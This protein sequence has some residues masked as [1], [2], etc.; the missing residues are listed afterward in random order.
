MFDTRA[1]VFF[2][3]WIKDAAGAALKYAVHPPGSYLI[4]NITQVGRS[5]SLFRNIG[6][7]ELEEAHKF[8]PPQHSHDCHEFN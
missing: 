4:K 1:M 3:T 7:E 5:R 2:F 8:L 6:H